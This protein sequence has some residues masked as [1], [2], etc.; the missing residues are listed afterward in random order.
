MSKATR[1]TTPR[2]RTPTPAT[3]ERVQRRERPRAIA[4]WV[5]AAVFFLLLFASGAPSPLYRV[6]QEEWRF[7]PTTLTAVF[8]INALVLLV[9]LLVFGR[10]SDHV[11]RRWVIVA[12][13][14]V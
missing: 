12:G 6:Y 7:S 14:A 13:L 3:G 8:A 1:T 11:G 9:M 4:F 2:P 10:L 5:M